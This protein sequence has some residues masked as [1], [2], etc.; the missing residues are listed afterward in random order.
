MDVM[1]CISE[2]KV[3][4]EQIN[5]TTIFYSFPHDIEVVLRKG[6]NAICALSDIGQ[7]SISKSHDIDNAKLNAEA[8]E[9]ASMKCRKC[10]EDEDGGLKTN[11]GWVKPT[12]YVPTTCFTRTT[13]TVKKLKRLITIGTILLQTIRNLPERKRRPSGNNNERKT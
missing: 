6:L 4:C 10:F 3:H 11:A 1:V 8:H 7:Q 9:H 13:T 12:K 5:G 2:V